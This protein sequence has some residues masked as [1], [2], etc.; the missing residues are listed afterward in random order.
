MS[1]NPLTDANILKDSHEQFLELTIVFRDTVCEECSWSVP[2]F[3]R[4]MRAI[5]KPSST[6]KNKIIPAISNADKEKIAQL[7]DKLLKGLW[8]YFSRYRK[9]GDNSRIDAKKE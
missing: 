4:K 8:D 6:R 1:T 5:D 9:G 7:N 3:Y 2:T